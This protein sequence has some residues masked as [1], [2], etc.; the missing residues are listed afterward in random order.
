MCHAHNLYLAERD[1]GRE[2]MDR[3]RRRD[4]VSEPLVGYGLGPNAGVNVL[5]ASN[6]AVA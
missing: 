5:W 6:A 3:Y 1:Y 2:T 4:R